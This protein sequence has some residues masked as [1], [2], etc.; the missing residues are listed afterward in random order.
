MKTKFLIALLFA[1]ILLSSCSSITVQV[2]NNT[3]GNV[4]QEAGTIETSQQL[5]QP[6]SD[7]DP[8][9]NRLGP[10]MLMLSAG[11]LVIFGLLFIAYRGNQGQRPYQT[12]EEYY[13]EKQ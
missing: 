8:H 11:L 5:A 13:N 10:T 4:N 7:I 1:V 12:K 9:G 3:G 6:V 2:A